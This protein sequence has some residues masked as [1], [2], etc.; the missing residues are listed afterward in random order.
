MKLLVRGWTRIP[1]SYS[2]VNVHTLVHLKNKGV[3]IYIQEYKYYVQSWE[4]TTHLFETL[5]P[6]EYINILKEI[7]EWKGEQV[8][9]VYNITFPYPL[10]PCPGIPKCVFYTAEFGSLDP[11]FFTL[12]NT[13]RSMLKSDVT[14]HL[15][16]HKNI[17]FTTP[18]TWSQKGL[19]SYGIPLPRNKVVSHG[20]NTSMYYR[21]PGV[22]EKIRAHYNIGDSDIL[23]CNIGAMSGNKGIHLILEALETLVT[24]GKH[25]YKLLL[26]GTQDLYQSKESVERYMK[27]LKNGAKILDHVIFI[28]D[29]LSFNALCD[30]FNAI[31]LYVSPYLAEGFNLVPLEVIAS[32]S[33][34]LLPRTGCTVDYTD[35]IDS[36]NDTTILYV[37]SEVSLFDSESMINNIQ[38]SSI[39]STII[40]NEDVLRQRVPENEYSRTR[41]VLETFL[42]WGTITDKLYDYFVQI[43]QT[44]FNIIQ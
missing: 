25:Q 33:R 19:N 13:N 20:V 10:D 32:G 11:S 16:T 21:K 24:L 41:H 5:Y 34:V 3:R 30:L 6:K 12:D 39:V 4:N 36:V 8:D 43:T 38:T 40:S 17:F 2:I 42:D 37:D 27:N 31:D 15:E 28:Q 14:S 35:I 44:N 22:R 9:L 23:L 26:K 18:S 7:P 29:T 1:H